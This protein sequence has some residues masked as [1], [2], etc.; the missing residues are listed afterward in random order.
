MMF[1]P[2]IYP[3]VLSVAMVFIMCA[4]LAHASGFC[5]AS[6]SVESVSVAP[7]NEAGM[8]ILI[9]FVSASRADLKEI[10]VK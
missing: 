1:K 10:F 2:H 9:D 6:A 4:R 7:S 3:V 5:T 8:Y